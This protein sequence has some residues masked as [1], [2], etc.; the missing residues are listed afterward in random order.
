MYMCTCTC[1]FDFVFCLLADCPFVLLRPGE[2]D[3][4]GE[5]AG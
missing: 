3:N 2:S 4:E 5:T 1:T